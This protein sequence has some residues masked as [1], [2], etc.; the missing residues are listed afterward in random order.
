M[1]FACGQTSTDAEVATRRSILQLIASVELAEIDAIV[2]YR[3]AQPVPT[4]LGTL[5]EIHLATALMFLVPR[6]G[7]EP[8]RRFRGPG[9]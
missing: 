1:A 4:K 7:I 3:A 5:D 9:F 2:L 6:A 8:A